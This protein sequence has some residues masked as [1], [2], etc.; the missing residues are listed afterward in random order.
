MNSCP[1]QFSILKLIYFCVFY[2]YLSIVIFIYLLKFIIYCLL[3]Q[4]LF[5]YKPDVNIGRTRET[6]N[7]KY[8]W[9]LE[10]WS[11]HLR[12]L[13]ILIAMR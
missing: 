2:F 1:I 12:V 9:S 3:L 4:C 5:T 10:R 6:K 7:A 11:L 8:F 13:I